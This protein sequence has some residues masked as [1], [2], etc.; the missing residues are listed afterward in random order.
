MA[1]VLKP[2]MVVLTRRD[3]HGQEHIP[4]EGGFVIA[5]NHNTYVDPVVI[6]HYFW[7]AGRPGHY[8]AKASLF[9]VPFVGMVLRGAQ[10]I[11]VHRG[12]RDASVA[13]RDAVAA[14]NEGKPVIVYPEGTITRD[15]DLWPMAGK[16]GAARIALSTGRPV[17][18][19][20]QWGAH[21]LLAPY[22]KR[23]SL[24]PRKRV[25]V[26]AGPPVDL[27]EF[28]GRELSVDVLRAATDRIMDAITELLAGIRGETPPARRYDPRE[29]AAVSERAAA[30]SEAIAAE[31]IEPSLAEIDTAEIG[32]AASDG[33]DG[34]AVPAGTDTKDDANAG[35]DG[36]TA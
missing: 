34:D 10:Q 19:V 31:S 36:V 23:P 14:V 12:S 22:G 2:L 25:H 21:E 5:V 33:T 16:T 8:L 20:A 29:A 13:F 9:N 27:S 7:N 24:F 3:W 17:I 35:Q 28:E 6:G 1:V 15:P 30:E 11:P 26:T 18:P 32:T 4:A